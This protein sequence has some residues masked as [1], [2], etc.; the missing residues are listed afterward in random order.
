M[1]PDAVR[2]VLEQA[3]SVGDYDLADESDVRSFDSAGRAGF[4]VGSTQ[5]PDSGNPANFDTDDG[6]P[7]LRRRG[8]VS[9]EPIAI[10]V[11]ARDIAVPGGEAAGKKGVDFG[12]APV[13]GPA[14]SQPDHRAR[15]HLESEPSARL[16]VRHR[17]AGDSADLC[18]GSDERGVTEGDGMVDESRGVPTAVPPDVHAAGRLAKYERRRRALLPKLA[19]DD[20]GEVPL[21]DLPYGKAPLSRNGN[22]PLGAQR[23]LDEVERASH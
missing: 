6:H 11:L 14:R 19:K 1:S 3:T 18:H 21:V 9:H 17:P 12:S 5:K 13:S 7:R 2:D 8:Q 23:D 15:P 4:P 10:D 20:M 16:E 22:K